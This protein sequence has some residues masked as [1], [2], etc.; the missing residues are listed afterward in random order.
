MQELTKRKRANEPSSFASW[1]RKHGATELRTIT[2][3]AAATVRAKSAPTYGKTAEQLF[4][5]G[6]QGSGY[7]RYLSDEAERVFANTKNTY[8][9]EL[10]QTKEKN[11]RGYARYLTSHKNQQDT[12]KKQMIDRI[13]R[14]ESFNTES[15]YHQAIAAGLTDENARTAAELGV[16]AAKERATSRLLKMIL[17]KRLS[18]SR[19][20]NYALSLGFT[21]Q[22]AKRFSEYAALVNGVKIP[23]TIP[24]NPNE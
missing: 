7:A 22:E 24:K 17:E 2:P 9:T 4:E 12:L 1:I 10:S 20:E 19:T 6:L 13:G 23:E 15:A 5:K 11:L 3:D 14:G 18:W 8:Q 16:A 21:Q